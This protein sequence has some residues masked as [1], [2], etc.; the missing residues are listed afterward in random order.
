M[1][2]IVITRKYWGTGRLRWDVD[3]KQCCLGFTCR[4]FGVPAKDLLGYGSPANLSPNH[5]KKFPDWMLEK[6]PNYVSDVEQA[7]IINDSADIPMEEKEKQLKPIFAKNGIK[8]VF[9]GQP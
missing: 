5:R 2:T 7:M 8:L 4:S 1:K 9:R 3:G 6:T